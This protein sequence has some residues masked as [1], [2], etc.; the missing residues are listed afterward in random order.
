MIKIIDKIKRL[1]DAPQEVKRLKNEL[2]TAREIIH[3]HKQ[4]LCPPATTAEKSQKQI[5]KLTLENQQLQEINNQFGEVQERIMNDLDKISSES[6]KKDEQIW[7]LHNSLKEFKDHICTAENVIKQIIQEPT[8]WYEIT[9]I[10]Q[11]RRR[12]YCY[13]A[14]SIL[15]NEVFQNELKGLRARSLEEMLE[16]APSVEVLR[17]LR[18]TWNGYKLLEER[19][20]RI[21]S[22]NP[23]KALT[24]E[25]IYD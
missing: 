13:K 4:H 17:D 14:Q 22:Y 10:P 23:D 3:I 9:D 16:L 7:V 1:L 15:E 6:K 5:K 11:E 24:E 18:M 8:G 19:L 2:K 25:D 21:A 20:K 12:D